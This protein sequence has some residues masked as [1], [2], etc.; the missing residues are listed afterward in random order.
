MCGVKK[1]HDSAL[2]LPETKGGLPERLCVCVCPRTGLPSHQRSHQHASS[3][4]A[5]GERL[6]VACHVYQ[7]S[8]GVA[9]FP[10]VGGTPER[11]P[12]R[13]SSCWAGSSQPGEVEQVQEGVAGPG[14]GRAGV[15]CGMG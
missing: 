12:L 8:V 7:I 13:S 14:G 9:G 3:T 5:A 4:R 1:H 10:S 2:A 15:L 6:S 11:S